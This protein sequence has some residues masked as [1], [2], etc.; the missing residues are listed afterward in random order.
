[1]DKSELTS[2]SS[3]PLATYEFLLCFL[4]NKATNHVP[5]DENYN[6]DNKRDGDL[7]EQSVASLYTVKMFKIL[8]K[9]SRD[10]SER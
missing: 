6:D 5:H 2:G 8:P 7:P 9:I 1:M 3:L 10:E 4:D